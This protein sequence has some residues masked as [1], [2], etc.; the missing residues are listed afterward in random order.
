MRLALTLLLAAHVVAAA[1]P[2]AALQPGRW[3]KELYA[4]TYE[5]DPKLFDPVGI[6]GM[7]VHYVAASQLSVGVDL[8]FINRQDIEFDIAP[9]DTTGLLEYDAVFL[10]AILRWTPLNFD[11]VALSAFA[12]PGYSFVSGRVRTSVGDRPDD[13]VQGLENDSW[14]AVGGASVRWYFG[15][16]FYLR[17]LG[18]YR[19]FEARDGEDIDRYLSLALGL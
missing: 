6:V 13:V 9:P 4:G 14:S 17:L 10:D 18:G 12:G 3:E 16:G 19:W 15:Q 1:A 2:A 11:R 5:P 7:R 8:G